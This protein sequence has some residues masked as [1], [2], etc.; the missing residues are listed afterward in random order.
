MRSFSQGKQGRKASLKSALFRYFRSP[1][2]QKKNKSNDKVH[3]LRKVHTIAKVIN[4]IKVISQST[5][6]DDEIVRM[7]ILV[8][9]E[10]LEQVRQLIRNHTT[11]TTTTNH[12]NNYVDSNRGNGLDDYEAVSA[13]LSIEERLNLLRQ[14]HRR[15]NSWSPALKTIPEE[16]FA[17]LTSHTC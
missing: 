6:E 5:Q 15:Q 16:I 14:M 13:T 4:D 1:R 8:R 7:K 10:G 9:K 11:V 3:V 17:W 2:S 12:N